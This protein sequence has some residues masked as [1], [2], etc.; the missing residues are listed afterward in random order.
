[1]KNLSHQ[2]LES[3]SK[4]I[5]CSCFVCVK[6]KKMKIYG[7]I[8]SFCIVYLYIVEGSIY[9]APQPAP[10]I[11]N[12]STFQ[13]YEY[14]VNNSFTTLSHFV[15]LFAWVDTFASTLTYII[16]NERWFGIHIWKHISI[17][18]SCAIL[19]QEMQI[20]Q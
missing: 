19:K 14:A 5:F 4:E 8:F 16:L 10:C 1:M 20:D 7:G 17:T 2:K 6:H 18:W 13:T 9:L 3:E 15:Y 11:S 12:Q